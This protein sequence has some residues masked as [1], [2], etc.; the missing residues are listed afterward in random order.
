MRPA[1]LRS[2]RVDMRGM[3]EGWMPRID[4]ARASDRGG[5]RL[6]IDGRADVDST[7]KDH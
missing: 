1:A 4:A 5:H 7:A 3:L 6:E 2:Y